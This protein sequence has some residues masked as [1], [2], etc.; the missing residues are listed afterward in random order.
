MPS[1]ALVC[2]QAIIL[3]MV[4][5]ASPSEIGSQF[6]GTT[7]TTSTTGRGT[8]TSVGT[9]GTFLFR[10]TGNGVLVVFGD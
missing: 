7:G 9:L 2:I 1:L 8:T 3:M 10:T 5:R 6:I 4:C